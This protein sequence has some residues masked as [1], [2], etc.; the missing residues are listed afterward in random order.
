MEYCRVNTHFKLLLLFCFFSL[1]LIGHAQN[2]VRISINNSNITIKEAL[3]EV[4]KQSKMSIAYNESKLNGDKRIQLSIVSQPLESALSTILAGTGFSY[5]LKNEY[6][7]IVP[8]KKD[9]PVGKTVTGKVLDEMGSPLPGATVSVRGTTVG[10]ITDVDGYFS[11]LAAKG[12]VLVVSFVGYDSQNVTVSDK[13]SYD[14]KLNPNTKDLEAVVVTALGIKRSEK[15]LSYNVQQVNSDA[16]TTNKDANFI[17]ALSGKVAGLNIN[18]SS[19]GVGGISK[20][21]MRGTKSIMQSS[22]A[23][24]VIDGVP[25]YKQVLG[26]GGN[27]MQNKEADSRGSTDPIADINPEDIESMSVLTGAAAAALYGSSAAN[28]AIII[29]TKKGKE[30]RINISVN[31]NVEFGNPFVMP[32]FQT[33]Y[34]RGLGG[35]LNASPDHSWG[36][37]QTEAQYIKYDPKSD[38]F[39]T[40]VI[41]T[42]SVS[43]STGTDKNQ[44]YASAAAINSKGIVPNNKYARYN[45]TFRNTTSFLNDKMSLDV[46]ANYIRQEDRNLTNQGTYNNPMVGAYLYPRGVDWGDAKAYEE[47]DPARKIYTQRWAPGDASMTM[48][49]P[50]WINYRNL[51]ENKKDRYMLGASLSYQVLDWLSIAGRIRMDNS[52]ND[53]TE[54]FFATTNTQLTELSNRGLF[55]IVK[56]K[57]KQLYGD[58]LVSVNKYFGDDWS[59]QAN[60]GGSFND[61]KYDELGVRGPIADGSDAFPGEPVGLTNEFSVQN[62]SK[63]KTKSLQNGWHEQVQSLY[64]SAELGYKSTYYLTLTGRNDWPSQLAGPRSKNK[65]F[66][67]PSVGL[68]AVVSELI[69]NLNKNY[70]SYAKLR[71]SYAS[72]GNAFQRYIAN[73]RYTWDEATGTW[74]VLTSRPKYDLKPERTQSFEVGLN[75]RFLKNFELDVTYY[76]S[77][78]EDQVFEIDGGT[79]YSVVYMQSGAVRNQGLEMALNYN[80]KWSN[81]T[82]DTGITFSMNRNK[83]LRLAQNELNPATGE[84]INIDYMNVGGLGS[85]RFILKEGG[86]MGDLY[87]MM[88]L[89]RDANGAIYIDENNGVHTESIQDINSYIKLGSVSPKAN[90]AWRNNFSWKNLNVGFMV[91]ARLGGITFSRTQAILDEYGV[92]DASAAA[93]DRGYVAVNGN[94]RVNPEGWYSVVAGGTA[95]PQYYTYS[96]TNV[97]LQEA[98]I[99]Y[100]IPRRWIGNICDVKV[101][102]VGRNLWMIYNKAPFDPESV[103]RTDAFYQGIDYFILPSMRTYGFNIN[104][105]F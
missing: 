7:I 39:Q 105:K 32:K 27:D 96:A 16:I 45:F 94:D 12:T 24:Y 17:N 50:Y 51:R 93:R 68:S 9:E 18:A 15:A 100:T 74:V 10:T 30:G 44:T 70:L 84:L 48:Q 11:L 81:F 29:N 35:V 14:I 98:S 4:E 78:T 6:I 79:Q 2:N 69:P 22:D 103:S 76:N 42:E 38:Y 86:D 54:K 3:Q 13:N 75:L 73:P 77:K 41:A 21:T 80:N 64:A 89:R 23:L 65:S 49:N 104:L 60:L 40:G 31:S 33:R 66:F 1:H 20:V 90:L 61:S 67:Y 99:G 85:T 53:F 37:K 25:M 101:S 28:G 57:D 91:T 97:R 87:S 82:W 46:N 58:F 88:D 56:S 83:I 47:Y 62:L 102:L 5:Q 52:D 72:V 63:S 36:P 8:Q 19:S 71:A 26:G 34:A 43:L 95:V 92:S 59:L 55:G